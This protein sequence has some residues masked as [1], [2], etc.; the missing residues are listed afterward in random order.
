MECM[1]QRIREQTKEAAIIKVLDYVD[2]EPRATASDIDRFVN[3]RHVRSTSSLL[4]EMIK[5]GL[6][7][8]QEVPTYGH[9]KPIS[10]TDRGRRYLEEARQ[11][12]MSSAS[13][14]RQGWAEGVSADKDGAIADVLRHLPEF[15]ASNEKRIQEVSRKLAEAIASPGPQSA[16]GDAERSGR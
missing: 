13:G 4:P 7:E 3:V 9:A 14:Q 8:R 1:T 6:I 12:A 11:R 15:Q 2:F 16:R 10:I 5:A